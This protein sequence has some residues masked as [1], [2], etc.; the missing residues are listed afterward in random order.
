MSA[1][2]GVIDHNLTSTAYTIFSAQLTN[3]GAYAV[4]VTNL[5]G[6]TSSPPAVLSVRLPPPCVPSPAGLVSWWRAEND[7]TDALGVNHDVGHLELLQRRA[8]GVHVLGERGVEA[9]ED[10]RLGFQVAGDRLRHGAFGGGDRVS[11]PRLADGLDPRG[12]VAH[13]AGGEFQCDITGSR[14]STYVVLGSTDLKTWT[15][16]ATNT[17]PFTF[18]DERAAQFPYRLYRA[19]SN[20]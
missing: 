13:L 12:D 14:D 8:Q 19:R 6:S 10:Q 3:S 11:H 17:A 18:T 5:Y 1:T 20:P 9:A 16:L 4:V 7:A 15:P 2:G